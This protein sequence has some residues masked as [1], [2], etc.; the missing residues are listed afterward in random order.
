[1]PVGNKRQAHE[2]RKEAQKVLLRRER[3]LAEA[4][5]RV[6]AAESAVAGLE[7]TMADPDV[8]Q[9]VDR[10]RE[11]TARH[12]ALTEEVAAAYAAWEALEGG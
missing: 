9:E 6:E 5:A 12:A 10:F 11:L 2:A 4:E 3:L 8:Y 7:A 1:M